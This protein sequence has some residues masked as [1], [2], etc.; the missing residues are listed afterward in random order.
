MADVWRLSST[1]TADGSR[2]VVASMAGFENS[3][4]VCKLKEGISVLESVVTV[5]GFG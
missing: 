1:G 2:S 3:S 4:S 5:A